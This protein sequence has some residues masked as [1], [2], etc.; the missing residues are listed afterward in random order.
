MFNYIKMLF[1]PIIVHIVM[2]NIQQ[3]DGI[4]QLTF[5]DVRYLCYRKHYYQ[6]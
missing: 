4:I 2:A 6:Q 3:M 5:S 1:Y